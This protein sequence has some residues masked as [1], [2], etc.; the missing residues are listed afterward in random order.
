MRGLS[1]LCFVVIIPALAA[2][3]YDIYMTY[4]DQDFSKPMMFSDA[5][6][7][8][9]H[10]SPDTFAQAHRIIDKQTWDTYIAPVLSS[11]TVIVAAVPAALV[12]SIFALLWLLKM[13]PFAQ[14]DRKYGRGK[15]GFKNQ[16]EGRI[17]YK[18]K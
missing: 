14:E 11:K 12:Y 7:L 9:T 8:W 3:G 4:G 10:Y 2:L 17:K 6:Y 16:K 13:G 5:G 18:R 15:F 1:L